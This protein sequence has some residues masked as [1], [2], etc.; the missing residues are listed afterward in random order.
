MM[1]WNVI[2]KER[3]HVIIHDLHSR[4][5]RPY[6]RVGLQEGQLQL[7]APW[8]ALSSS[9]SIPVTYLP[10]DAPIPAFIA[11]RLSAIFLM[12]D[13]ANECDHRLRRGR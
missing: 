10:V 13:D 12:G 5:D 9:Q 4:A 8:Q 6:A 7:Q 11:S 1:L 2:F 3:L